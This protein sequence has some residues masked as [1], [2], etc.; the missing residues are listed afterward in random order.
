[1]VALAVLMA[2]VVVRQVLQTVLEFKALAVLARFVLFGPEIQ[3][4]SRQ[5]AQ[6]INNEPLH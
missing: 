6:G 4:R 1:M 5:L 3:D 2:V